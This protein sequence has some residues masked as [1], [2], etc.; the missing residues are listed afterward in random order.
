V[1]LAVHDDPIGA[2]LHRLADLPTGGSPPARDPRAALVPLSHRPARAH[3]SLLR[4]AAL[5]L[6]FGAAG[7]GG[8]AWRAWD[9][10]G[11]IRARSA[12][13]SAETLALIKSV[14]PQASE[15]FPEKE[16]ND[17]LA[18]L[19]AA[20]TAGL[21]IDAAKPILRELDAISA[22]LTKD[23]KPESISLH[24]AQAM[25]TVVVP[26]ISV[27]RELVESIR[28]IDGSA[29]E[30]REGDFTAVGDKYKFVVMGAWRKPEGPGGTP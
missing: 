28:A 25:V 5:A 8:F 6:L 12:T 26:N 7:L 24:F 20:Q 10:A 18:R 2:T 11:V 13:E 27:G 17:E 16:L 15:I 19:R 4:A 30:W 1:D 21:D 9:A 23:M 3:R 22:V 29:C 14:L